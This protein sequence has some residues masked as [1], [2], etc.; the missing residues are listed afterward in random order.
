MMV[1]QYDNALAEI[2]ELEEEARQ[3]GWFQWAKKKVFGGPK[4]IAHSGAAARKT[5]KSLVAPAYGRRSEGD[6]ED[7]DEYYD[8]EGEYLGDLD[9]GEYE[10]DEGGFQAFQSGSSVRPGASGGYIFLPLKIYSTVAIP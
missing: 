8:E 2:D 10:P 6:D 5:R 1:D 9:L 3:G 4:Q 7:Y